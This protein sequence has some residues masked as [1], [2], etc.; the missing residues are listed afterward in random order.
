M[1]NLVS[2]HPSRVSRFRYLVSRLRTL[3]KSR[4]C[5]IHLREEKNEGGF[6]G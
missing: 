3:C 6:D 2:R 5:K 4:P 1:I